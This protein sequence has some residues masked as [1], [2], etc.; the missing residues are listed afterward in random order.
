[1]DMQRYDRFQHRYMPYAVP[2]DWNCV[3][4]HDHWDAKI[5]CANCGKVIAFGDSFTSQ[6]IHNSIGFGYAVCE[7]CYQAE[8]KRRL[9]VAKE[10]W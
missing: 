5:N 2:Y 1:M 6:E 10:G 4:T 3:L 8:S 9:I 7:D